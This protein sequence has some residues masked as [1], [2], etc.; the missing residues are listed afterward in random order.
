EKEFH[1]VINDDDP[2]SVFLE[3]NY[4]HY[5]KNI[6]DYE[7]KTISQSEKILSSH[8]SALKNYYHLRNIKIV[9]EIGDK[10][11]E[12]F[13][14]SQY[15]NYA[16]YNF[17]NAKTYKKYH[18][19]LHKLANESTI[20]KLYISQTIK[21]YDLNVVNSGNK[22]LSLYYFDQAKQDIGI[23]STPYTGAGI[24]VGIYEPGILNIN[25][26]HFYGRN[27][28]YEASSNQS[29]PIYRNHAQVVSVIAVGND[30]IANGSNIFAKGSELD[31]TDT[32]LEE[33]EW[34]VDRNVDII[35]VSFR[36]SSQ[37]KNY[38]IYDALIDYYSYKC[39]IVFIIAAGN[40]GE[41]GVVSPANAYSA[42][43]VGAIDANKDVADFSS[44]E[45]D[46]GKPN[47]V[48]P[49]ANL[50]ISNDP[51]DYHSGTS[52]AAPMVTG[53]VALLMEEFP[54][55]RGHPDKI[56][57]VL[58]VSA[59]KLPSQDIAYD[60]RVGVGLVNYQNARKI[61]KQGFDSFEINESNVYGEVVFQ[62]SFLIPQGSTLK[63][64]MAVSIEIESQ[65]FESSQFPIDYT[66]LN[67]ELGGAISPLEELRNNLNLYYLEY[68]NEW[69]SLQKCTLYVRMYSN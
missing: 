18:N 52:F 4:Q 27:L 51:N 15:S 57:T 34:F 37:T 1:K 50:V 41:G 5:D 39:G 58:T 12:K 25:T 10:L 46:T 47:I 19:R 54:Y 13:Y 42:I 62:K 20:K 69:D 40:Q 33:I 31:E 8:R 7:Y 14:I 48:A 44:Y 11:L 63:I 56:L 16:Q 65:E 49:G 38:T 35:N 67:I 66:L 9:E 24:N 6:S 17:E 43:T 60:A 61:I 30:G 2:I 26:A 21:D 68:T 3:F 32:Y 55:L 28:V 64:S 45:S 29:N 53:I 23:N 36:M 59:E 22:D